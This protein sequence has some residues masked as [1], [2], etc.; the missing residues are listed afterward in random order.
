MAS[1][2]AATLAPPSGRDFTRREQWLLLAVFAGALLL[3]LLHLSQIRVHDPFF[4]IP[5]VDGRLYH[6]QAQALT[7]GELGEGVLILGPFYP[8]FMAGVYRLFGPSLFALKSLQAAIGAVDCLLLAGLA[9]LCFDGRVAIT[10][11]AMA[12][13][14]GMLV[15]YGGTVMIVNVMVPLV[16]ASAILVIRA[17]RTPSAPRWLAAGLVLSCA[18]LARQTLLLYAVVIAGWLLYDL[19]GRLAIGARAKCLA[20]FGLGVVLLIAPFTLR[21]AVV[22]GDFVLLNSTGG[23]SLYMGN[24]ERA[25]GAWVPPAF[26][27]RVDSP[28]A[29]QVAFEQVA[30]RATGRE[31]KPSEVSAYWS[32][33]A[34]DWIFDQPGAWLT[35]ELR[36]LLLFWNAR[37]IWNNRSID[38]SREFSWVLRLPL[39]GYGVVAP[40]ALVGMGLGAR[41]WR[42]LFPLYAL[43]AV[44]LASALV[45]FVL[46]R[47]RMPVVPVLMIFAASTVVQLVDLARNREGRRFGLLVGWLAVAA[48]V[49]HRDM[50][51]ENLYM[52]HFNVGN[53]YRELGR[54]EE[55]IESYA[56]SLAIAPDFISTHNNLALAY[57]G[58]GRREQ[59]IE[60]WRRVLA[61][62]Q[63]HGDRVRAERATRHLRELDAAP[64]SPA[65]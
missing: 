57:E 15:F 20:A 52:A 24:N 9:R 19:R 10:S 45:F 18:I 51:R 56:R 40:L 53:K 5:A 28:L 11:A 48:L 58:A 50:G 16:L 47:Y 8:W 1:A 34:L 62:S 26:G 25:N 60:A 49:V 3:R 17:L 42:E 65:P 30:E 64:A 63:Q 43:V 41:R 21:N 27:M 31:L 23:I 44:H 38:I 13:V 22:G 32:A 46:S 54:Y 7:R 29:M 55:A 36:K 14:Y 6:A 4:E 37:E 2:E 39:L 59:A 33:R 61:W 12:A 35:L